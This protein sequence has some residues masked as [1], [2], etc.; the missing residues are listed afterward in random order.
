MSSTESP[1]DGLGE[2]GLGGHQ[3]RVNQRDGSIRYLASECCAP[4]EISGKD[5]TRIFGGSKEDTCCFAE[6]KAKGRFINRAQLEAAIEKSKKLS[7]ENRATLLEE[8]SEHQSVVEADLTDPEQPNEHSAPDSPAIPQPTIPAPEKQQASKAEQLAEVEGLIGKQMRISNASSAELAKLLRRVLDGKLFEGG[9]YKGF[10]AYCKKRWDIGRSEAYRLIKFAEL[11]ELLEAEIE[12]GGSK[13]PFGDMLPNLKPSHVSPLS[14]LPPE[15][16]LTALEQAGKIS[17]GDP[18]TEA[19]ISEAVKELLGNEATEANS[20]GSRTKV[21][22]D[23]VMEEMQASP[24]FGE[25]DANRIRKRIVAPAVSLVVKIEETS[26]VQQALKWLARA[27]E[28]CSKQSQ[29]KAAVSEGGEID[30]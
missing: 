26:E 30:R 23:S 28:V 29:A 9:L 24:S 19:A 13:S 7:P 14:K 22:I 16:W 20:E 11:H 1:M 8:L 21:L 27:I 18:L 2:I 12:N 17:D 5:F 10:K 15:E 3:V 6:M 25:S 4:L